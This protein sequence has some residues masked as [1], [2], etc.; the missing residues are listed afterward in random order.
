[1]AML[2]S[3]ASAQPPDTK[4]EH[5]HPAEMLL[6]KGQV[7]GAHQNHLGLATG[8]GKACFK[9]LFSTNFAS[10]C[11]SIHWQMSGYWLMDR[12]LPRH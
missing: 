1:M 3:S 4:E 6:L 12:D 5:R 2:T 8:A 11:I 9:D 7:M 10:F